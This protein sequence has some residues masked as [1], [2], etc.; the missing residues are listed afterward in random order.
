MRPRQSLGQKIRDLR[1]KL[2][3]TQAQLA[4]DAFTKSF[5]SQVEK[6]LT[7][8]S[9][10][11]LSVIAQRLG[12]PVSYFVSDD[13][14]SHPENLGE[15]T[16][17]LEAARRLY[18]ERKLG[19]AVHEY[20]EALRHAPPSH[21]DLV[22]SI[23]LALAELYLEQ[24]LADDATDEVTV[25][26]EHLQLAHNDY[27]LARAYNMLGH[28]QTERKEHLNASSSFLAGLKALEK[29]HMSDVSLRVRL[30]VNL[31]ISY[32]HLQE[33]HRSIEVLTEAVEFM[34]ETDGFYSFGKA[35]HV[36]G[37]AHAKLGDL[38]QAL[39]YTTQAFE[40]YTSLGQSDLAL[41]ARINLAIF[42]RKAG[43][44]DE[45]RRHLNF[46]LRECDHAVHR[47]IAHAEL[48]HIALANGEYDQ[49]VKGVTKAFTLA[50]EHDEIPEWLE[51]LVRAGKARPLAREVV[52][53]LAER[54]ARWRGDRRALAEAHSSLGSLYQQLGDTVKANHHLS[55][56]VSLFKDSPIP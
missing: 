32:S 19:E 54:V 17:H 3:L 22:A 2:N 41:T 40:L 12:V 6:G 37:Y 42:L 8:P 13:P 34:K 20:K 49:V 33:Y 9:L 7:T 45:A 35:C 26:I 29:S 47:A 24:R 39:R 44:L 27:M 21:H 50:P 5:I 28:L 43:N 48:A 52:D 30:L 38:D 53:D 15:Y 36:L 31:G 25:A 4:G 55:E 18:Q 16:A 23:H 14:A 51:L 11:S 1:T 10:K 56:S 46:V